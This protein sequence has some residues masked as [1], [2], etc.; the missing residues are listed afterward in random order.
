MKKSFVSILLAAPILFSA[1]PALAN[2]DGAR[3]YQ[4]LPVGS[5]VAALHN[6]FIDANS[7]FDGNPF[8][9]DGKLSVDVAAFQLTHSIDIGGRTTG[10]F[11]VAPVGRVSGT[12]NVSLPFRPP[13][14]ISGKSSGLGDI[15]VGA[16]FGIVGSPALKLRDYVQFKPGFA[17]GAMVKVTAPTG[18]Y[19]QS[20]VINLGGH[21]WSTQLG[22]PMGFVFGKS[23]L[24]P[25]L[26]TIEI[27]PSITIF[28]VNDRPFRALRTTQAPLFRLE[29]HVTRNLT[30]ALWVSADGLVTAGGRQTTDGVSNASG[31][32]SL[33]L[34]ATV[35]MSLSRRTMVKATYGGV[36]ARNSQGLDGSGFR[37]IVTHIF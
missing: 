18:D 15:Q 27:L 22:A 24:D 10:V 25:K 12:A 26:T 14:A 29:T 31:Q 34:G 30:Q 4:L 19:D 7:S 1:S 3:A 23:Y 16:V 13:L 11:I 28:G 36:V 21:R 33:E 35:G 17:L 5:N 2:G 8:V 9:S 6:I 32:S 37:L 20:Q